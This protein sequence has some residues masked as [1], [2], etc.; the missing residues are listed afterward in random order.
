MNCQS[1]STTPIRIVVV[2]DHGVVCEGLTLI[3]ERE[4][5]IEVVATAADGRQG[6][7][8]AVLHKPDIVVMDLVLPVLNGIDATQRIIDA[9]PQSRVVILSSCDTS[10]HVF[11]AFRAGARGYVLKECAG[12]ELVHAIM[13]VV[14]G[15]RYLS[16]QL[17][18]VL[19]DG[20]L[21][22]STMM[23]PLESLSAREREVMNLTV[24]GSSSA[25][26]ALRLCLSRKTVDT[27]R[28]RVMLKLGV[29]NLARLIHFGVEHAM[30][31]V[32]AVPTIRQS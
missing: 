14:A 20:L 19:I 1:A 31:P 16:P 23:S 25:Q 9:L 3:L 5:H 22:D 27:Y 12:A 26:I 21:S 30:T 10:E 11:S 8:A 15:A 18:G 7:A 6:I 28:S 24:A 13:T 32:R 17:T 2:D 4:G 29:P